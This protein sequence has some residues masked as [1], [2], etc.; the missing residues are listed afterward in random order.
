MRVCHEV[1][2]GSGNSG[3]KHISIV[4]YVSPHRRLH[5]HV[6][7]CSAHGARPITAEDRTISDCTSLSF[8]QGHKKLYANAF[9]ILG[10]LSRAEGSPPKYGLK[11]GMA[12]GQ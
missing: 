4:R 5:V 6:R 12:Q 8:E 1:R 2:L 11:A 3:R 10:S 7:A 9:S